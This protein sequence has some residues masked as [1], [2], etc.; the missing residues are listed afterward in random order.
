LWPIF[1]IS[2]KHNKTQ[3][4]KD[5]LLFVKKGAVLGTLHDGVY[6]MNEDQIYH[7]TAMGEHTKTAVNT[8]ILTESIIGFACNLIGTSYPPK[9]LPSFTWHSNH[10]TVI[11]NLEKALLVAKIAMKRR[12]KEMTSAEEQLFRRVFELT[13]KEKKFLPN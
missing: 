7:G 13:Q 6:F 4:E 2:I 5:Y 10:G 1:G 3:I 8:T 9:Y 12:G 11:Y